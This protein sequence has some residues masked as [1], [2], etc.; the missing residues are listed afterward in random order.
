MAKKEEA[1]CGCG[2]NCGCGSG[3]GMKA[4][5][6]VKIVV[7]LLVL[8]NVYYPML[9]WPAFIGALIVIAGIAKLLHKC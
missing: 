7:G 1:S 3:K 9:S 8:G 5:A 2:C 6:I 4:H